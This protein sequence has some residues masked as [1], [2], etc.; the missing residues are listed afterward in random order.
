MPS[1]YGWGRTRWS[2]APVA[3][4]LKIQRGV[5]VSASTIRRWL[6]REGGVGKRAQ[7]VARADDPERGE[8]RARR[9]HPRETLEQRDGVLFADDLDLPLLPTGGSQW[10]PQ[11]EPVK[12][13]T[14]GQTQ[15]PYLAG[16]LEPKTGRRGHCLATR[17]PQ[18]LCRALLDRVE[19]HDAKARVAKVS[20]VVDT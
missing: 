17:K 9:R 15:K 19:A 7:W 18:V 5:E 2:C 11:G 13:V 10:R 12:R 3:G 8:K 4:Q 16:A 14:P 20:G 6:P 1:A